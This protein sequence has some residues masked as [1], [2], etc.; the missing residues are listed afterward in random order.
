K[1]PLDKLVETQRSLLL[2]P[3]DPEVIAAAEANGAGSQMIASAQQSPVWKFVREWGLALPLHPEYRTLPML[4]Y[5]PPLLPVMGRAMDGVYGRAA[6]SAGI[7]G[8][9]D[10]ARLPTRYLAGLFSAG[11][12]EV[13]RASLRK[14]MAVRWYRRSLELDDVDDASARAVLAEAGLTAKEADAI[15][16]LTALA[17]LD[18]RFVLPPLQREQAIAGERAEQARQNC[19]FG[20]VE[21]PRRG[22]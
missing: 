8:A 20:R 14:L 15:Y 13:V 11:N 5:V 17:T 16:R 10:E 6:E 3:S 4:F 21:S 18:E 7:F 1:A 2:D 19:G 12:T 22:A 9:L